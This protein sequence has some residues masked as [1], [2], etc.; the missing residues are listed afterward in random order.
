MS[1]GASS[2]ID[3][4]TEQ[5]INRDL[6]NR[7]AYTFGGVQIAPGDSVSGHYQRDLQDP[8]RYR[9]LLPEG[10]QRYRV[11]CPFCQDTRSRL[12][13]HYLWGQRDTQP[14]GSLTRNLH[15][16]VCYN[17]DCLNAGDNRWNLFKRVYT[18]NRPLLSA[19]TLG[20][21][22]LRTPTLQAASW[23]G[24]CLSLHDLPADH[25]A[26]IYLQDRGFD[27]G[28]L[29]DQFDVRVCVEADPRFEWV[30]NSLIVPVFESSE[31]VGWQAR[32]VE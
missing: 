20:G 5:P 7:L 1:N 25:D 21:V 17:E 6:Y 10:G 4:P 22:Q 24:R 32:R 16:A 27:P 23:P 28:W 29:A 30:L 19:T 26:K 14:D 12:Y 31:L 18:V 15:L 2:V 11:N 8:S 9:F 13:I 3:Y